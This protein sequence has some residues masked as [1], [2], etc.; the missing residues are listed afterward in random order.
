MTRSPSSPSSPLPSATPTAVPSPVQ[1]NLDLTRLNS[2]QHD[3]TRADLSYPYETDTIN[4]VGRINEYRAT[5][6]TGLAPAE[7]FL[8]PIASRTTAHTHT[9]TVT[10][11]EKGEKGKDAKGWQF[12]TWKEND[13]EDPRTWSNLY[14]WCTSS[15]PPSPSRSALFPLSRL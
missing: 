14:R 11:V 8:K 13:P 2:P 1:S 12:V 3:P 9:Q 5:S 15:L 6:P 4:P 7:R 10:D